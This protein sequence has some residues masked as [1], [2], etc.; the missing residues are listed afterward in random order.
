M[1]SSHVIYMLR[2]SP[3]ILHGTPCHTIESAVVGLIM[4]YTDQKSYFSILV[5]FALLQCH[6]LLKGP[7]G[8]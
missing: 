2:G 8:I 6:R 7:A 3:G 1:M 5:K 4:N